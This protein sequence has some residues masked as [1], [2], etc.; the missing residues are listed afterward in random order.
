MM[1]SFEADESTKAELWNRVFDSGIFHE[2]SKRIHAASCILNME[3]SS[4]MSKWEKLHA[5]PKK[6]LRPLIST[7]CECLETENERFISIWFSFLASCLM[8]LHSTGVIMDKI[9]MTRL[10]KKVPSYMT[11]NVS[12]ALAT[13][14]MLPPVTAANLQSEF[15][16][17][18]ETCDS[19][20][21]YVWEG[22]STIFETSMM[23]RLNRLGPGPESM[24]Q[25]GLQT[26]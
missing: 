12:T 7:A 23:D 14:W 13:S 15:F 24:L 5:S 10:L 2:L 11:L 25:F 9:H 26:R 19:G 20:R 16:N 22:N 1:A 4:S 6:H 3:A 17:A 8:Q 18:L 21:E